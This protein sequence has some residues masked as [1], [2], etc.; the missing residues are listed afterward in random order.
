MHPPAFQLNHPAGEPADHSSGGE[1]YN[2]IKQ[3]QIV[4]PFRG[5][6]LISAC[7]L[8]AVEMMLTHDQSE[9]LGGGLLVRSVMVVELAPPMGVWVVVVWLMPGAACMGTCSF[10]TV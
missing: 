5:L 3:V 8:K 4:S 1:P 10:T 6:F 7:V 9:L 2:E